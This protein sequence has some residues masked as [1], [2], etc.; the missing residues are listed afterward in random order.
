[1][2]RPIAPRPRR[3][4]LEALEN[5][6]PLAAFIKIPGV[7]G[8]SEA[9]G[10][11]NEIQV[12]SYSWVVEP[13]APASAPK[14]SEIVVTKLVD[15]ASPVLFMKAA[16]GEHLPNVVLDFEKSTGGKQ[17]AYLRYELENAFIT[18]YQL[19]GSAESV[20]L[21]SISFQFEKIKVVYKEGKAERGKPGSSPQA[22]VVRTQDPQAR[23]LDLNGDGTADPLFFSFA[24]L[25]DLNGDGVF[26]LIAPPRTAPAAPADLDG[27]GM[28]DL[29]RPAGN[30]SVKADLNRDGEQDAMTPVDFDGDGAIDP[31]FPLDLNADGLADMLAELH[32]PSTMPR[33]RGR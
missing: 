25:A 33:G 24:T 18:S 31:L 1:M 29:I 23:G 10:H 26:A 9:Q 16:T 12:L 11:K 30:L 22:F 8:E 13:P 3:L 6:L 17:Q 7:D 2:S 20:P 21:E 5:R 28:P 15:S 32:V 4:C 27:D 14:V 19:G